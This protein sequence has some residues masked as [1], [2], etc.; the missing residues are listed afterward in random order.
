MPESTDERN[1]DRPKLTKLDEVES[2]PSKLDQ[3]KSDQSN[4][5]Q[6]SQER[7]SQEKA[8]PDQSSPNKSAPDKSALDKSSPEKPTPEKS[9]SDQSDQD[10]EKKE[11]L[12]KID[13]LI[14]VNRELAIYL[15]EQ[16][17]TIMALRQSVAAIQKT[18]EGSPAMKKKFEK[19]LQKVKDD[20][21]GLP[22]IPW[23]N[24]IRGVLARLQRT[25]TL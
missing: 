13:K 23:T 19:C 16:L 21:E 15:E 10:H 1:A 5:E 22:D 3:S 11:K 24:R 8:N 4:P 2:D 25:G 6:S 17:D 18:L 7:S 14:A 20:G 12:E 9:S